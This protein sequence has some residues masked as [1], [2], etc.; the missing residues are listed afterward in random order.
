MKDE[1]EENLRKAQSWKAENKEHHLFAKTDPPQF[2]AK[3][4]EIKFEEKRLAAKAYCE[5]GYGLDKLKEM[6]WET[7][8]TVYKM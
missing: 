4:D 6:V 5:K 3:E 1:T 8:K 2:E 7:D